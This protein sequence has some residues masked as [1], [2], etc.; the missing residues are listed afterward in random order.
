MKILKKYCLSIFVVAI[1]AQFNFYLYPALPSIDAQ[2]KKEK[3]ELKTI[4]GDFA[5]TEPVLIDLL[6]DPLVQRLKGVRQYGIDYYILKQE[7]YTRYD[8]SV[9]VFALL[10]FF[11]AT[12][13]E[14]IAGLLHD[15]S[16]TAFSHLA[17]FLYKKGN[18]GHAYQDDIHENFIKNSSLAVVLSAHGF[19]VCDIIHKSG[20]FRMLEQELPDICADRLEYNLQ[21]GLIQNLITKN[22]IADILSN[23]KYE[24]GCWFFVSSSVAKKFALISLY[25]TEHRWSSPIGMVY[26]TWAAQALSRAFELNLISQHDFHYDTDDIVWQKLIQSPDFVLKSLINK[27]FNATNFFSINNIEYDIVIK[28]KFR[29]IN[30]LVKSENKFIR[31]TDI[32]KEFE[33]EYNRVK[34]FIDFGYRI[35]FND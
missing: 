4:Y 28:G 17:D 32:D 16:H 3:I 12:I 2:N 24:N 8:H 5:I 19:L 9:G 23:L 14:Q 20:S 7:Y 31:L 6:K 21:G 30:P 27:I 26:H 35:K 25:M 10:R 18:L 22:D 34:K 33:K 15:V 13:K 11:G 1:T 29:G